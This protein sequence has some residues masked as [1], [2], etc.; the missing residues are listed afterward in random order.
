MLCECGSRAYLFDGHWYCEFDGSFVEEH[1]KCVLER[2]TDEARSRTHE[3]N[4]KGVS[5]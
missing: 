5:R 3:W 4:Q 1:S 2:E